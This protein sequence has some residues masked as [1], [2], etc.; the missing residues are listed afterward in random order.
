[1]LPSE[2]TYFKNFIESLKPILFCFLL[3]FQLMIYVCLF[4]L[5]LLC[6]EKT[7]FLNVVLT[8]SLF[9]LNFCVLRQHPFSDAYF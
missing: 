7:Y 4:G 3:S 9:N 1:M 5:D 6:S 2:K 8:V